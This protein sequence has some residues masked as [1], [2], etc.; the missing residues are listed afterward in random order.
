MIHIIFEIVIN[1]IDLQNVMKVSLTQLILNL[2][3]PSNN[4]KQIQY[5]HVIP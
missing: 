5:K 2:H 1:L 3:A 4:S